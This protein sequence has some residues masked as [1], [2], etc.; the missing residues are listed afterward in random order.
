MKR[1]VFDFYSALFE[2]YYLPF[3]WLLF[4]FFSLR[5]HLSFHSRILLNLPKY[6]RAEIFSEKPP[7][8]N[9]TSTPTVP[10][11]N[12]SCVSTLL[13]FYPHPGAHP[14]FMLTQP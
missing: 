11:V 1:L 12:V 4:A 3:I 9:V 14:E 5:A 8:R 7:G 6:I 13:T 2:S 10:T